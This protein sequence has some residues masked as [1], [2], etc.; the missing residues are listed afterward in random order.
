MA[1]ALLAHEMTARGCHDVEVISAGTWA[2]TGYPAT[3]EVGDVLAPIGVDVSGHRSQPLTPELIEV[4]D[5]VVA[6]TSVH[7]SEIARIAP[8]VARKTVL[9]KE[10]GEI[11]WDDPGDAERRV[12]ALLDAPRPEARRTL[13]VD[14][15]IGLPPAAYRRAYEEISAGIAILADVICPRSSAG[16]T[17]TRGA[18]SE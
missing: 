7:R 13:D 17:M 9:L 15:P 14:D 16:G 10:L 11:A 2:G 18:R 12:A 6:M 1:A 3:A 4:A 8:H 5:V